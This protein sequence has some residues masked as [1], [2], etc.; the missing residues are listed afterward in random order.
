MTHL[1]ELNYLAIIVATIVYFMLGAVWYSPLMF[2][3]SWASMQ[4]IKMDDKSRLPIMLSITFVLNIIVSVAM[5]LLV[6]ITFINE[7]LGGLKL[8]LLAGVGFSATTIGITF[9]Y[10]SRP[11]KIYLI[12]A[13]YHIA[14]IVIVGG[15]LSVWQ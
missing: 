4:N 12:D 13:G 15:I 10:E 5:M 9:L 3:K 1:T 2:G 7:L 6:K 8:G 14:G 11:F